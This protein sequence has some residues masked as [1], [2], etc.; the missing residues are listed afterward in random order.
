MNQV[1]LDPQRDIEAKLGNVSLCR[2]NLYQLFSKAVQYPVIE[3]A[4]SLLNGT[5]YSS[6]E[7]SINWV[8]AKDGMYNSGLEKL[9]KIRE[10]KDGYSPDELLKKMEKEYNRLFLAPEKAI[11]SLYERDYTDKST[12]LNLA[13]I[14]K[15]YSGIESD[16]LTDHHKLPDHIATEL[17]YIAYLG[18]Q[19]GEAWLQS[20]MLEA[21]K[22]KV[23]ERTFL[24][25]HLRKWGISFFVDVERSTELDAY[26]AIASVGK[27]FMT[28]EHGN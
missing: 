26:K 4:E 23:K 13:S 27:V 18:Q 8:N 24:V 11:V 14:E 9:N 28:L 16:V 25:H 3:L 17:S 10:N 15:A 20:D 7:Q 21:K 2:A 22:W 19:E 6:I 12:T 1:I 5:F